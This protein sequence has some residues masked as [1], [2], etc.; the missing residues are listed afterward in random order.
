MSE[1]EERIAALPPGGLNP[2][3]DAVNQLGYVPPLAYPE[4]GAVMVLVSSL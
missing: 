1:Q 4:R 3:L 2:V